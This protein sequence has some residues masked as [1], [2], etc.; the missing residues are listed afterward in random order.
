MGI[1]FVKTI[2]L[3]IYVVMNVW[4]VK[5]LMDRGVRKLIHYLLVS[6]QITS[7]RHRFII[8]SLYK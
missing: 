3:F 4:I 2:L 7:L 5:K 1:I 8:M 6:V